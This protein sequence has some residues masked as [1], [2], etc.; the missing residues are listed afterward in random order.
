[1]TSASSRE[2]MTV[3][4]YSDDRRTR[5]QLRLAVGRR[6]AADLPKVEYVECATPAAVMK[7]LEAGDV[8]VAIF[9]GE[10]V[11]YGGIGLARQVKDEI[12]RCPPVLVV[13]GRPQDGWLATWSRADA[14]VSH[15]IDPI[16][17]AEALAELMRRTLAR[18]GS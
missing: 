3:L 15:P 16:A 12:Y 17:L 4:I 2:S 14:V 8:D 9:D 5:E 10:A 18:T 7:A 1:M 6:P 13:V 11:P